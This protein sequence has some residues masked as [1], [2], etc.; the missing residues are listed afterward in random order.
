M[1]I[2]RDIGNIFRSVWM[3]RFF[4][5]TAVK[6]DFRN[7]VS[8]SRFGVAWIVLA[9]LSQVLMYA[10][11]LSPLMSQ[12][13][14]GVESDYSYAIYLLAGFQG[15]FLFVEILNRNMTVFV[16]NANIIKKIKFPLFALPVIVILNSLINNVIFFIIMMVIFL[17]LGHGLSLNLAWIPVITLINVML[18]SSAGIILGILNVFLRDV[19]HLIGIVIQFLFWFTP[20]VYTVDILPPL[21]RFL[22]NFN[23]LYKIIESYHDVIVFGRAPDLAGLGAVLLLSAA[24]SLLAMKLYKVSLSDMVD[25]L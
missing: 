11:V 6:S 15:W 3:S 1:L 18:C 17:V 16:D 2:A 10:F 19:G 20:I 4:I 25:E 21:L 13:L 7:R 24:V 12:R 23:P 14:V 8:R 5:Y 9:P 22:V